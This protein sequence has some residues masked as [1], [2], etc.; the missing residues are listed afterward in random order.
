MYQY[1]G[2]TS[3]IPIMQHVTFIRT[4]QFSVEIINLYLFDAI[5]AAALF[6]ILNAYVK[7]A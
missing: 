3:Y 7:L 6:L 5:L 4:N 2:S 1:I